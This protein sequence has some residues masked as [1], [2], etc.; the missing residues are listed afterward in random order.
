MLK[1]VEPSATLISLAG[2]SSDPF[3]KIML[4]IDDIEEMQM[5]VYGN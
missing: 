1:K 5:K 4:C 3:D 2:N